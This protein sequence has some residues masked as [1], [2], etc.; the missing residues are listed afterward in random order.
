VL[1][2]GAQSLY[3]DLEATDGRNYWRGTPEAAL[4]F[5]YHLRSFQ[6]NAKLILAPDARPWR[7]TTLPIAELASFCNVIAPQAYW[8]TFDSSA[9]Y[10]RL[11]EYGYSVD[12]GVTPEL[13]SLVSRQTWEQYGLPLQPVGQGNAGAEDWDR[14]LNA[15][16]EHSFETVSVWRYGSTTV[17]AFEYLVSQARERLPVPEPQTPLVAEYVPAPQTIRPQGWLSRRRRKTALSEE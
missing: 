17:E 5:G 4:E 14:F 13:V 11:S 10:E 1:E 15:S 6:P 2:A 16:R 8:R 12:Q 9:N 7:Q 3:L